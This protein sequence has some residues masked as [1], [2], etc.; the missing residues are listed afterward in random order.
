MKDIERFVCNFWIFFQS[1]WTF[2]WLVIRYKKLINFS[3]LQSRPFKFWWESYQSLWI[4]QTLIAVRCRLDTKWTSFRNP[5]IY[6]GNC[7]HETYW[8]RKTAGN[9]EQCSSWN[10]YTFWLQFSRQVMYNYCELSPKTFPENWDSKAPSVGT[11]LA[12][13]ET[14]A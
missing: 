14:T 5:S 4:H 2:W 1:T 3:N 10:C 11:L 12:Y 13:L 9:F 6:F 7:G 8:L